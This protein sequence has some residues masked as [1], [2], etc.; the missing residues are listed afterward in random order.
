MNTKGI[1]LAI[2]TLIIIIIGIAVLAGLIFLIVGGF[3]TFKETTQPFLKGSQATAI[4]ETCNIACSVENK[5]T[6]CCQEFEIQGEMIMCFDN[7]LEVDC[8]LDCEGFECE[9]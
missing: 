1:Q 5:F 7:R 3:E 2:S 8:N 6:Y 4:K 9:A